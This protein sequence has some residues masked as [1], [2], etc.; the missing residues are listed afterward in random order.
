MGQYWTAM[1]ELAPQWLL[2]LLLMVV[3][4]RAAAADVSFN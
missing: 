4:R 2:L 1:V 3:L